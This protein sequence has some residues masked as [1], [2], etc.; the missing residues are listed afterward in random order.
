M[1][2]RFRESKNEESVYRS[3]KM[4][5][6]PEERCAAVKTGM[7]NLRTKFHGGGQGELREHVGDNMVTLGD[8]VCNTLKAIFK[9]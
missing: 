8:L 2:V 4:R 9:K 5:H 7:N 1:H 3:R 6:W